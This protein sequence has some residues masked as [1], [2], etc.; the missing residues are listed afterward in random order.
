MLE[1]GAQTFTVGR[2]APGSGKVRL[3]LSLILALWQNWR[4][5]LEL[6]SISPRVAEDLCAMILGF[7]LQPPLLKVVNAEPA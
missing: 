3:T 5:D 1:I 7:R 2:R 6:T 4:K